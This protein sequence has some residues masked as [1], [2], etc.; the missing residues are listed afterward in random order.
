MWSNE[1][2]INTDLYYENILQFKRFVDSLNYNSSVATMINNIKLAECLN[3]STTLGCVIG[4]TLSISEIKVSNYEE[5]IIII[6]KIKKE[7][8]IVKQVKIY[9]LQIR[10]TP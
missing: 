3:Y 6:D 10:L 8:T 5:I 2:I 9:L 4:L 7:K 1:A